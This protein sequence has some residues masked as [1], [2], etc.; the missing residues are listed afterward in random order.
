MLVVLFGLISVERTR[1]S[2]E[3]N[4]RA[5]DKTKTKAQHFESEALKKSL[6]V[7]KKV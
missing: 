2:N 4:K 7:F 6:E 3:L 5:F 1:D